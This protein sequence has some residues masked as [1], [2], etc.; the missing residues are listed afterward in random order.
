MDS[1]NDADWS[2]C[3]SPKDYSGLAAGQHTFEVRATDAVGNTD[4]SAASRTWTVVQQEVLGETGRDGA[5][6]PVIKRRLRSLNVPNEGAF[7]VATI[8]CRAR[9]CTVTK[10]EAKIK[11]G[12]AVYHPPVT[13]EVVAK[14]STDALDKGEIAQVIVHFSQGVKES[15]AANNYG[16]LIVKLAA[17]SNKGSASRFKKIK[18]K[19]KF[20]KQLLG[21]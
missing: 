7:Q 5:G 10:K 17:E 11:I 3:T 6:A 2:P 20:L 14:E 16:Q 13:V 15:L 1:T 9:A 4:A 18:L 19:A 12:D 21:S 8:T